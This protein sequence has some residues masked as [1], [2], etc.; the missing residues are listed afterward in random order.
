[1]KLLKKNKEPVPIKFPI[2]L[3]SLELIKNETAVSDAIQNVK[4]GSV[5]VEVTR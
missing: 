4:K 2:L 1:M 3:R 5:M